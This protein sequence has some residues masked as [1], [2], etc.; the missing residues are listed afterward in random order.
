MARDE[1]KV[2]SEDSLEVAIARWDE[3][4]KGGGQM[5]GPSLSTFWT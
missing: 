2:G 5:A 4:Q 3:D 1:A